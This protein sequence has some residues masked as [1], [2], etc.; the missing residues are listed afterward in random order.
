MT[1]GGYQG[2]QGARSA[3]KIRPYGIQNVHTPKQESMVMFSSAK[4]TVCDS[5]K[6]L[7]M[8]FELNSQSNDTLPFRAPK[9][10]YGLDQSEPLVSCLQSQDGVLT[11]G[12]TPAYTQ[13]GELETCE[14]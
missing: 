13:N 2:E 7:L 14:D 12:T 4:A 9:A 1:P 10:T 5:G 11:P 6:R 3:P 8:T